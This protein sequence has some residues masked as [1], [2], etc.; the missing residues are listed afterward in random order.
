MSER[1]RVLAMIDWYLPGF[2]GGGPIRSLANCVAALHGDFDFQV[3][4]SA[5]D[6]GERTP[7]AGITPDTWTTAPDGTPA[8]YCSAD[9]ASY[10]HMRSILASTRFDTLY[11]NSMFSLRYTLYP[12]WI[13]RSMH[14]EATVILA[15]RG[16]LHAGALSLKPRKKRL[17]LGFLRLMG[18]H[19]QVVFHATDAQEVADVRR[20][21]GEGV[22]VVCASNLPDAQQPALELI[23]KAAGELKLLY[24][25]RI[26]EKKGLHTLL[27]A[28]AQQKARIALDV[29]G[30]DEEPGYWARCEALITRLPANVTVRKLPP[31]ATAE[32]LVHVRAA[33]LFAMPTLGENF[34]HAIFE[35]LSAGRPVLISDQTPWRD[36]SAKQAGLDLPLADTAGWAAA[37][38]RFAEMDQAAWEAYTRGA[39]AYASAHLADSTALAATKALLETR[40]QPR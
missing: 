36:L 6:H 32:G 31:V 25:S 33:H 12:L 34:G 14:P 35:A 11:L 27:A 17:F 15:P 9:A 8:W 24:L 38:S 29:V 20:V 28:L 4:T 21:F 3:V 2:K 1:R 40:L 5:C 19:K 10:R 30:P 16:M 22:Q 18:M 26:S 39:H 7:Y 23:P 37:I 13:A